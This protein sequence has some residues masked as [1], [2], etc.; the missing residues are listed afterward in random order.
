M[1]VF[2]RV[3]EM[4]RKIHQDG[5][6]ETTTWKILRL[7]FHGGN[8]LSRSI[9][10]WWRSG[11]RSYSSRAVIMNKYRHSADCLQVARMRSPR[12]EAGMVAVDLRLWLSIV[13]HMDVMIG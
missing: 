3:V 1:R 6:D 12:D 10:P 11:M 4:K 8:S 2:M 9:A 13:V 5:R 7:W